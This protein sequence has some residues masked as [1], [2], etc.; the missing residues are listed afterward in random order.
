MLEEKPREG[1]NKMEKEMELKEILAS[2]PERFSI[3]IDLNFIKTLESGGSMDDAVRITMMGMKA[4]I[5]A[6]L[7]NILTR[8][9]VFKHYGFDPG[10][11][12]EFD[13]D[14]NWFDID[15]AIQLLRL[16]ML[17]L[18]MKSI[19]AELSY[20]D[21]ELEEVWDKKAKAYRLEPKKENKGD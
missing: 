4:K 17:P 2:F 6:E 21:G 7:K 13:Y 20:L 19:N 9:K 11:G 18:E 8:Y 3:T 14:F 15:G 16:D 12:F 10:D 5:Q 1:G